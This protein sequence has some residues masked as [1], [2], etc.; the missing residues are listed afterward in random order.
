[1]LKTQIKA[2]QITNLTDARYFAAW[3]VEWLGFNLEKGTGSYIPPQEMVEIKDWIEGPKMV[4]ELGGT[5]IA[6]ILEAI[7]IL[8]L[9]AVQVGVFADVVTL[10][11]KTDIVVFQEIIIGPD[12]DQTFLQTHLANHAS[13]VDYFILNFENQGISW[14]DLKTNQTA[15]LNTVNQLCR[16]HSIF[17]SIYCPVDQVDELLDQIQPIGLNVKGGEEEKVG[18]KSFDEL[19]EVFEA[20]E[21]LE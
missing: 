11:A 3:Y 16:Q 15:L 14:N 19:D 20:L 2:S 7:N 12:Q 18:V 8:K 6:D 5:E 1:M 9:D 4:G 17:I 10:K 13:S 21:I